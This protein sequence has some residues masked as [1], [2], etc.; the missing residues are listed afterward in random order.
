MI[1]SSKKAQVGLAVTTVI[2]IAVLGI[3]MLA[4]LG[5]REC[6]SNK[7]CNNDEYCGSDFACHRIPVIE[8]TIIK[9]NFIMPSIIIGLAIIMASLILK[10]DKFKSKK[11]DETE[12]PSEQK[13]RLRTP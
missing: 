4:N 8:K 2:I 7:S 1:C 10:S 6:N 9:N 3:G 11:S 5:G 13:P 12:F